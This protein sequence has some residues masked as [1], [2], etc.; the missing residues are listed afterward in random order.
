MLSR[1]A[2]APCAW[3]PATAVLTLLLLFALRM[4]ERAVDLPLTRAVAT[5]AA[6]HTAPQAA[7]DPPLSS[8]AAA[9]SAERL[10]SLPV[11]AQPLSAKE[12]SQLWRPQA[13]AWL[14]AHV[15]SPVGPPPT[16]RTQLRGCDGGMRAP[17]PSG[18]RWVLGCQARLGVQ[19]PQ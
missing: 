8:P 9:L 15:A 17:S 10:R 11:H 12:A 5:R 7:V 4:T 2:V 18:S 16:A 3:T 14:A 19:D 1:C 6:P 13:G